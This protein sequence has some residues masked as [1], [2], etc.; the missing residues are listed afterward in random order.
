MTLPAD[1]ETYACAAMLMPSSMRATEKY[2]SFAELCRRCDELYAADISDMMSLRGGVFSIG[3]RALML[4]NKYVREEERDGGLDILDGTTELMSQIIF[5]PLLSE[6]DL[7]NEK[8]ILINKIK[9]QVNDPLTFGLRRLR[10]TLMEGE[11]GILTSEKAIE[12]IKGLTREKLCRFREKLISEAKVEFFYCGEESQSTVKSLIEKHFSGLLTER[13]GNAEKRTLKAV[14]TVRYI[15]ED[16]DYAQSNLL[17]GFRSNVLLDDVDFYAAELA[18][19][20]LGEG[21]VSKLFLN[22]REKHSLCY[23]C[24]S[25]Y[26]EINGILTVGCSIAAKDRKKAEKEIFHQLDLIKKGKIS[27]AELKAAKQSIYSDCR[28]AEDHPE[29]YEEFSRSARLFGGPRDIA[30]YKK[31]IE[32]VSREQIAAAA[33]KFELDTVYFLRGRL[34]E[35]GEGENV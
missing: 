5:S 29:D 11:P 16:G 9:S 22:L 8:I 21:P 13:D 26:D 17:L 24:G 18:N 19:E 1:S 3:L 4:G 2:G 34:E 12:A 27:D 14:S 32:A 25:G 15:D 28:E 30:E 31:N 23:F 20:I 33:R 7:E 6:R 35:N 10:E